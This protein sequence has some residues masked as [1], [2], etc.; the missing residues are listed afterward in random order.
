MCVCVLLKCK[1]KW[2]FRLSRGLLIQKVSL[3]VLKIPLGD[4]TLA[5]MGFVFQGVKVLDF[6]GVIGNK[7]GL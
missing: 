2:S 7:L 4:Y 1:Y 5:T 6:D 3:G